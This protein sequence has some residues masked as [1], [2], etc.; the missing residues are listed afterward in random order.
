MPA[1]AECRRAAGDKIGVP[2]SV[3]TL[4]LLNQQFP[5]VVY[6]VSTGNQLTVA[7]MTHLG[8]LVAVPQVADIV[9]CLLTVFAGT[10]PERVVTVEP[11]FAYRS[12]NN[13]ELVTAVPAIGK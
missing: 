8:D 6:P 11:A 7:I 9:L 4:P 1:S 5:A 13:P 10:S 3:V 2:A 12:I